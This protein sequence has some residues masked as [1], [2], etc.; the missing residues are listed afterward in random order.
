MI[1]RDPFADLGDDDL[2]APGVTP[3]DLH[4]A[5]G[6]EKTTSTVDCP[7]C[8]GRGYITLGFYGRMYPCRRCG[9]KKVLTGS[10][11]I[12]AKG[13]ATKAAKR[14]EWARDHADVVAYVHERSAA[15]ST[16]YGKLAEDLRTYGTLFDSKVEAVRKDIA[17][18]PARIAAARAK[19]DAGK[20]EVDVS[21]I[22]QMF[23]VARASGLK[24][25]GFRAEGVT[26]SAAAPTSSNPGALYV[27]VGTEYQGKI[28]GGKFHPVSSCLPTTAA[29][30]LEVAADPTGQ[31]KMYGL[32]TGRC[33]C[34]GAELTD[35]V[36]IAN[37]IGPICQSRWGL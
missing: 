6:G 4:M 1:A 37:G 20:V 28:A 31:A 14:E 21:R 26:I 2:D 3:A 36:S 12:H 15:G 18:A 24:R 9:G 32:K 10:K 27:K 7:K 16:F 30:V 19:R 34:C 17:E 11:A 13:E 8:Q 33:S 29:R 35:P 23:D 22:E 5:N 25:L